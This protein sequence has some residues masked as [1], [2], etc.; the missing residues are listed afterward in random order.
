MFI[1]RA[2]FLVLALIAG[3]GCGESTEEKYKK[4]FPPL[5]QDIK[6]LGME[7]GTSI[8][9]ASRNSDKKLADDFGNYAQKMGD[10][11]Q[12]IDDLE[13]P[14][15]LQRDQDDLVEAMGDIQGSLD[16]IA[17]AA[18][19]G[20]PNAAGQAVRQLISSSVDLRD[21]RSRLSREVQRL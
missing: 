21:A 17:S 1:R 9:N 15:D 18:E 10:L 13:P 12:E 16:D 4:D 6:D 19:Q 3:A 5:N 14:D 7:V 8:R 20:D 2:A 11:Q